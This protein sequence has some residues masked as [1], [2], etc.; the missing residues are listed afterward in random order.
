[1]TDKVL[2]ADTSP[3]A[4]LKQAVTG[5]KATAQ[6]AAAA[7][8]A[9]AK[10]KPGFPVEP[11]LAGFAGCALALGLVLGAGA[12]SLVG[13]R[14]PRATETIAQIQSRLDSGHLEAERLHAQMD[15]IAK[16]LSQLQESGEASRTE[17]KARGATLADR[18]ARTE[19][20]LTAKIAT[21]GEKIEQAEKEQN[22]HLAALA[23]RKP[24]PQASATTAPAAVKALAPEPTETGAIADKPKPAATENWAV[25]EVYDGVAM[26]EDRKRRLVEVG[27]GDTVPGVGRIE[28][29][30]RRGKTWVVVTRQGNITPQTW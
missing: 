9:A 16:S 27:P 4:L 1:M 29:I 7:S 13:G 19:Q 24:A 25:R 12:A 17:N 30:E 2:P 22:A 15:R 26:L 10:T 5:A 14:D 28:S 6:K 11:R 21:L 20:G 3:E 23:D 8:P 18:L